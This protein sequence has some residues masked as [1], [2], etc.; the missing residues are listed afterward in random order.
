MK[1]VDDRITNDKKLCDVEIGRA[2]IYETPSVYF[3]GMRIESEIAIDIFGDE[4]LVV[5][6]QTGE[7]KG[8]DRDKMVEP[9]NGELHIVD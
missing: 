4:L 3:I 8:V 1:A 7:L 9:I 5:N 6:L 2:F